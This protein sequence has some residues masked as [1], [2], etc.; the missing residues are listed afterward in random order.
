[1]P[2][3]PLRRCEHVDTSIPKQR[4][5]NDV[6]VK[7]H[8]LGG[9]KRINKRTEALPEP[10]RGSSAASPRLHIDKEMLAAQTVELTSQATIT[11][12]ASNAPTSDSETSAD[13]LSL[14]HGPCQQSKGSRA[15]LCT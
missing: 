8:E 2:L 14:G 3:W 15:G 6:P 10:R 7:F 11:T 5:L 4:L 12:G 13:E 9:D 1:M